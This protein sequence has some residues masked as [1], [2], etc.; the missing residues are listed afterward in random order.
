MSEGKTVFLESGKTFTFYNV[1]NVYES[2]SVL[3]FSYIAQS[4]K[5]AKVV[6]F[7]NYA[8][9]SSFEYGPPEVQDE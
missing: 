1:C 7:K 3:T 2:E 8:G 9:H 5:R 6:V 4:D